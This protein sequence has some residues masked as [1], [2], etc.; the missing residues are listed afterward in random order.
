MHFSALR[1]LPGAGPTRGD[2]AAIEAEWPLIAAELELV[3][4]ECRL[5]AFPVDVLAGRAY[6]HAVRRR[7][8]VLVAGPASVP[9]LAS[10]VVPVAV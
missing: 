7:L 9:A 10:G 2:L 8:A 5:A 1:N 4:A 3:E 6:R